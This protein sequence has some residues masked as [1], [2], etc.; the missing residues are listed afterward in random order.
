M[1]INSDKLG[2]RSQYQITLLCCHFCNFWYSNS[3]NYYGEND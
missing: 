2:R 1:K 3:R